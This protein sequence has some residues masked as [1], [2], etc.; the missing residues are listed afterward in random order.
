MEKPIIGRFAPSPTGRMH[1]GNIFA[2]LMAWLAAKSRNGNILLRIEDLDEQRSKPEYADQ[3]MRDLE[4]L[5]LTWDIGPVY[6]STRKDVYESAF[7][8]LVDMDAVYPCFCTRAEL[9]SQ[10]APHAGEYVGYSGKCRGL[11]EEAAHAK[12]HEFSLQ[13]R[14]CSY[15]CKTYDSEMHFRD[16]YRDAGALCLS[17]GRDDFILKRSDGLFAYQLAVVVDDAEQG[18]SSVVRGCDLLPSV[19][20]QAYLQDLLDYQKPEYGHVPLLV[21]ETGRRLSKR[22]RDAALDPML[23]EY[24]SPEAVLGHIAFRVGLIDE[25]TAAS[26]SDLLKSYTDERARS[27]FKG[28]QSILFN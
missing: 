27:A 19:A 14:N 6:Q 11:S 10:S 13:N 12:L 4:L 23:D 1:A 24:K 18:I 28:K 16:I 15:R 22:N 17:G 2:Y 7:E 25:D 20:K 9:N 21:D 5:G 3:I 8:I 26:A